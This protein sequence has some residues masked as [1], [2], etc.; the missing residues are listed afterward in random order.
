MVDKIKE[1]HQFARP[2]AKEVNDEKE[3]YYDPYQDKKVKPLLVSSNI[4][5]TLTID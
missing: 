5:V 4:L 2:V 1:R 3:H